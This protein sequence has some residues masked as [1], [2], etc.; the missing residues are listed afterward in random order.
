MGKKPLLT[1]LAV[2]ILGL[3]FGSCASSQ[4]FDTQTPIW[5]VILGF[6]LL[7]LIGAGLAY[8][9][10]I[11]CT[12][13]RLD[14]FSPRSRFLWI[15]ICLAAGFFLVYTLPLIIYPQINLIKITATGEKDPRSLVSEVWLARIGSGNKTASSNLYRL[16]GGNWEQ[17][18]DLGYVMLY[19]YRDQPAELIC[20]VKADNHLVVGFDMNSYSGKVEVTYNG[21]TVKENLYSETSKAKEIIFR[22]P[23]NSQQTIIRDLLFFADV[24][25]IGVLLLAASVYFITRSPGI[26]KDTPGIRVLGFLPTLQIFQK[27]RDGLKTL[28]WYWYALPLGCSWMIFLLAFWPGLA[29]PDTVFQW[30][31]IIKG[32]F[33]NWHP[34][35]HT[36]L[37]WLITRLWFSLAAVVLVQILAMSAV[38]GWAIAVIHRLGAASWL[39]WLTVMLFIVSPANGLVSIIPWKDVPYSLSIVAL[40]ILLLKIV[41]SRGSILEKPNVWVGLGIASS[42]IALF[43]HNGWPV[44]LGTLAALILA[45]KPYHRRLLSAL[46]LALVCW[47]MIIGPFYYYLDVNAQRIDSGKNPAVEVFLYSVIDKHYKS[48]TQFLPDEQA[49]IKELLLVV[50]NPSFTE[51]NKLTDNLEIMARTALSLTLRSPGITLK[52]LFRKANFIFQVFQPSLGRFGY[53][54]TQSYPNELGLSNDSKIPVVQSFLTSLTNLTKRP[55]TDWFFWRNAFWMYLLIF[56][57]LVACLRRQSWKYA[58]V[59]FP[60][61]FNALPLVL[62][63][64]G[65]IYRYIIPTI[66]VSTLLSGYLLFIP[67]PLLTQKEN[68]TNP[69]LPSDSKDSA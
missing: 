41:V 38:L 13:P 30:E 32:E 8:F 65:Q 60:V 50:N 33:T 24:F 58:L 55:K 52:H 2:F 47:G 6:T 57:T 42:L 63:S 39:T 17:N 68:K 7:T 11:R 51:W 29:S 27:L 15:F 59:T 12:W 53:V 69:A 28:D 26:R 49:L 34:A 67:F 45:Y 44:M 21:F 61:I 37:M 14:R 1:F 9:V 22:I 10:L 19:S 16:C 4:V 35:F 46:I 36:W 43:R 5:W 54:E 62:F 3:A 20:R 66:W 56:A 31:Q 48:G 23:L 64:D 25:C 18:W 40:T